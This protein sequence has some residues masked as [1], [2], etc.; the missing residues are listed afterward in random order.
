MAGYDVSL[1]GV[2]HLIQVQL[3]R[4]GSLLPFGWLPDRSCPL[5]TILACQGLLFPV[6]F[7]LTL[8]HPAK[9]LDRSP[10]RHNAS[11]LSC[12]TTGISLRITR[13]LPLP[14]FAILWHMLD[15]LNRTQAWC[16][17]SGQWGVLVV[18]RTTENKARIQLLHGAYNCRHNCRTTLLILSFHLLSTRIHVLLNVTVYPGKGIHIFI[19]RPWS[20]FHV[21]VKI[22]Q[23]SYS[24]VVSC[25]EFCC[26]E[27]IG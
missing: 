12:Q 27:Y 9:E 23:F 6:N 21:E 20:I 24:S 22:R 15:S 13:I 5:S 3:R 26:S 25:I 2:L 14:P 17:R 8:G 7:A 4:P 18:D 11:F 19:G 10:Y 16:Q 1:G